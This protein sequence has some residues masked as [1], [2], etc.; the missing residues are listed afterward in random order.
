MVPLVQAV[1]VQGGSVLGVGGVLTVDGGQPPVPGD[2]DGSGGYH[3]DAAAVELADPS[4]G[5]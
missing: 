1:D 5:A 4:S 2:V 3:G